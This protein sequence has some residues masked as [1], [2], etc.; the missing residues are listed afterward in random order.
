M[1]D[2]SLG[3][4]VYEWLASC[5]SIVSSKTSQLVQLGLYTSV[6]LI[7][8]AYLVSFNQYLQLQKSTGEKHVA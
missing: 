6:S 2:S 4:K 1:G 3:R 8:Y 7:R 5:Y